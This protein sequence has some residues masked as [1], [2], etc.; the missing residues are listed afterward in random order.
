MHEPWPAPIRMSRGSPQSSG[1]IQVRLCMARSVVN[2]AGK[3]SNERK[4]ENCAQRNLFSC[5][6]C[7]GLGQPSSC[8]LALAVCVAPAH[9]DLVLL[10]VPCALLQWLVHGFQV[11]QCPTRGTI[12]NVWSSSTTPTS[13]GPGVTD[14]IR[15]TATRTDL[16]FKFE[17]HIERLCFLVAKLL[18]AFVAAFNLQRVDQGFHFRFR[19]VMCGRVKMMTALCPAWANTCQS[20]CLGYNSDQLRRGNFR[21]PE[22]A[23]T[24]PMPPTFRVLARMIGIES[25]CCR[26]FTDRGI[27]RNADG[28]A[29]VSPNNS[30]RILYGSVICDS[31]HPAF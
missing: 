18:D 30:I 24:C 16:V 7:L 25:T 8:S 21:L 14:C 3:L 22:L 10:W 19:E 12:T 27:R 31:R 28:I 6:S 26:L 11:S 4:T 2:N 29:A 20:T 15:R 1:N 17:V 9:A 13:F 23:R 5:L